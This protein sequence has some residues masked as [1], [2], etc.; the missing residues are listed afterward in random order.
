MKTRYS[1][2]YAST[3]A[4]SLRV[5]N[6]GMEE[7]DPGYQWGP[8][9]KP[10]Y[11][12]HH[13]IKGC[14]SYT[15]GGKTHA[16]TA[17]DTF[18]IFPGEEIS[19]RADDADPWEY[20]WVGF[21][22]MG[23]AELLAH[24]DLSHKT[25]VLHTDFGDKLSRIIIKIC[26]SHGE[27]H[28]QK[29]YM[30]GHLHIMFGMLT[31]RSQLHHAVKPTAEEYVS[32]AEEYIA[33]NYSRPIT[34]EDI[35]R[36]VNISRSQLFRVF[37]EKHAQGPKEYLTALRISRACEMLEN[38][39]LSVVSVANSVGFTDHLY[40]STVFKKLKGVSPSDYRRG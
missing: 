28:A 34:V 24:T 22:G 39:S 36:H 5:C 14:G 40:F 13:I 6:S 35:A 10:N 31:E 20:C 16:L 11:I 33:D 12:I 2:K 30:A 9:V 3:D 26:D 23:A 17:G 37:R 18:L 19:Y 21:S 7:C 27:G 32:Q 25:P 38:T 15:V 29:V 8:G 4:L 1:Y